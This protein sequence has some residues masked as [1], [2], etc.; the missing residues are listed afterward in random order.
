MIESI[1]FALVLKKIQIASI[2]LG[3]LLSSA[4]AI[5]NLP[6]EGVEWETLANAIRKV[7]PAALKLSWMDSSVAS[8]VDMEGVN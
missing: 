4:L 2:A 6:W 8:S 1:A 7:K 5:Y 3:V